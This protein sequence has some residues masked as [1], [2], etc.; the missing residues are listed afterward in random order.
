M[1]G[2]RGGVVADGKQKGIALMGGVGG[3]AGLKG[4]ADLLRIAGSQTVVGQL[5]LAAGRRPQ[6]LPLRRIRADPFLVPDTLISAASPH[7]EE[8]S[9][10]SDDIWS[11]SLHQSFRKLFSMEGSFR[12]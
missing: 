10:R 12:E 5:L 9:V 11:C 8:K 7:S 1:V 6:L 3:M 2:G 4:V